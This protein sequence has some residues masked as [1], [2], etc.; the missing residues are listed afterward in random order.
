M[1][2]AA[3]AAIALGACVAVGLAQDEKPARSF[4]EITDSV[5]PAD[6]SAYRVYM[7]DL[8]ADGYPDLILQVQDTAPGGVA[9]VMFNREGSCS[10]SCSVVSSNGAPGE[11]SCT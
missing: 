7:H 8:D 2:K 11:S 9:V 4:V 5:M 1:R 3:I 10:K 6:P